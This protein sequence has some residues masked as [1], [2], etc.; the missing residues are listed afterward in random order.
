MNSVFIT[1]ISTAGKTTL[2][3]KLA[4]QFEMDHVEIDHLRDDLRQDPVYGRFANFYSN[5]DEAEYYKRTNPN[6][7]WED[8]ITQSK[9]LWP[10]IEGKIKDILETGKPTI[11]Q[12]VNLLPELMRSIPIKGIVLIGPSEEEIFARLQASPRWGD[13]EAL[14]RL[15]AAETFDQ[16]SRYGAEGKTYDY[17]VCEN[18]EV[19][20]AELVRIITS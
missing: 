14:Q 9:G 10:A 16:A 8:L 13:T 7:R 17:P 3:K 12:G 4:E 18:P 20:E 1:G 15:E 19:A 11:F 6:E 2:A 5:Q